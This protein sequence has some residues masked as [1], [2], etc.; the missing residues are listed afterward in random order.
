MAE[1]EAIRGRLGSMA[2]ELVNEPVGIDAVHLPSWGRYLEVG[3]EGFLHRV[4]SEAELNDT[5][6]DPER[7]AGRFA[8]K[9]AL[10]KVLGTGISGIGLGAVE[11][12]AE[13]SGRP[14]VV[15]GTSA[16]RIAQ[17]S[18]LSAFEVSICHEGDYALAIAIAQREG[19]GR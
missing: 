16:S 6:R 12:L 4:Y 19:Q 13:A 14:R 7:L 9:E 3:G 18:C 8:A 11:V 10:L 15:L 1:I 5:D 17:A 2:A